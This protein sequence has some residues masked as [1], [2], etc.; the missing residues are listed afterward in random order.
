MSP[1]KRLIDQKLGEI[2]V[3]R[4]LVTPQQVEE[5]LG[6]QKND[7]ALIGEILVRLKYVT[8]EAIAWALTV[9][10]GFPYLP[11]GGYEADPA[12]G[13]LIPRDFSECHAVVAIDR[14]GSVLTIAMANPLD[15]DVIRE[16]ETVTGCKIQIFISTLREVQEMSARAYRRAA[17]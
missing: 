12:V 8:E 13:A 15:A 17:P 7:G 6:I 9:Q 14:L 5:A 2:L 10:Y 1:E 16:L 4:G 11:L 3:S